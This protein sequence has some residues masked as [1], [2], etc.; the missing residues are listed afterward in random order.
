MHETIAS[1]LRYLSGDC[2]NDNTKSIMINVFFNAAIFFTLHLITPIDALYTTL[3]DA[4][5][6][7][8]QLPV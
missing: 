6:I 1:F 3:F 5:N 8:R 7:N 2:P 4:L